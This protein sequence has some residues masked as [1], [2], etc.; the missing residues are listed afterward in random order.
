[1]RESPD[2]VDTS[3]IMST[4][5]TFSTSTA[6]LGDDRPGVAA[7]RLAADKIRDIMEELVETGIM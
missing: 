3:T 7:G 6:D 1:M 5:S 4:S 2:E